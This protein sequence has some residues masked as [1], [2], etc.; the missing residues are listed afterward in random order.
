MKESQTGVATLEDVDLETFVAFSEF[1]HTN[2]YTT[3]VRESDVVGSSRRVMTKPSQISKRRRLYT[4]SLDK[5][6]KD[7]NESSSS[8]RI[9]KKRL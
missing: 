8:S 6:N 3:P 5:M 1:A 7:Y 9:A 2:D 4:A